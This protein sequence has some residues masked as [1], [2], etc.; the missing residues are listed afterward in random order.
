MF[1]LSKKTCAG[2]KDDVDRKSVNLI[3]VSGKRTSRRLVEYTIEL[4]APYPTARL[5]A[6]PSILANCCTNKEFRSHEVALVIR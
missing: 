4:D 2:I 6:R 3:R 1:A 5:A